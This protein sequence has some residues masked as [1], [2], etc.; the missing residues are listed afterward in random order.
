MK[1]NLDNFPILSLL[2]SLF[3]DSNKARVAGQMDEIRRFFL[4]QSGH[5]YVLL[6]LGIMS[7]PLIIMSA[8]K[9]IAYGLF[10][11]QEGAFWSSLV[12]SLEFCWVLL[13]YALICWR[14]PL[15]YVAEKYLGDPN[16]VNNEGNTEGFNFRDKMRQK[17]YRFNGFMAFALMIMWILSYTKVKMSLW[18]MVGIG[19]YVV[20]LWCQT[21]RKCLIFQASAL[22]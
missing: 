22:S 16:V 11:N 2:K 4:Q 21:H 3:T 9:D 18:D 15:H 6:S 1:I 17:T 10:D 20:I 12:F 13:L 5:W 8:G 14:L 19:V 7:V